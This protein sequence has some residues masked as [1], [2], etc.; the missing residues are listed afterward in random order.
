MAKLDN[1][2]L[3]IIEY[4]PIEIKE[5]KQI[6][7]IIIAGGTG[8]GKS[9]LIN[10][11]FGEEIAKTGIG[12]P[13]TDGIQEYKN[14]FICIW[15]TV[16]LEIDNERTTKTIQSIKDKIIEKASKSTT[17]VIHAI[18]Y[19][20][21]A[22]SKRYQ[23]AEIELIKNL[24]KN[25][26]VPFFIILTQAYNEEECNEFEDLIKKINKENEID[27][28]DIIQVVAQEWTL[29][30]MGQKLTVPQ[31]GLE[32][33][34]DVT[35]NKVP[36]YIKDGFIAAQQIDKEAKRKIAIEK[37]SEFCQGFRKNT[38]G[39]VWFVNIFVTNLNT[40]KLLKNIAN[41]Y[42]TK[43][44]DDDIQSII[45]KS[46]LDSEA[47]FKNVLQDLKNNFAGS[48]D[49]ILKDLGNIVVNRLTGKSNLKEF[50]NLL[51]H[52]SD[53]IVKF[54]V[55][56]MHGKNSLSTLD[57]I[58]WFLLPFT[59]KKKIENI[60]NSMKKNTNE[61]IIE[62]I[63]NEIKN[64]STNFETMLLF[65]VGVAFI[66]AMEDFWEND[67]TKDKID[68]INKVSDKIIENLQKMKFAI[69]ANN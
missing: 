25:N 57:N 18:W 11:V 48:K 52:V 45:T 20:V 53:P 13:V 7:N 28:I 29:K 5:D 21:N 49:K 8:V 26:K 41:V 19:C 1:E 12:L 54:I 39:K 31:K 17:D 50:G 59:Q 15:D 51:E 44:S 14:D 67:Y 64:N 27:D 61:E 42:N 43:F 30:I 65:S 58:E 34:V 62:A 24:H 66:N 46:G 2:D 69:N 35:V 10:A 23:T 22:G 32:K 36:E 6:P 9:T 55:D 16:G 37:L 40:K 56:G 63:Q 60:E 3:D 33:L 38:W 4:A 68:Q 47:K